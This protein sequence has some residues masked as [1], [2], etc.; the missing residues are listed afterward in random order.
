M[1]TGKIWAGEESN[2]QLGQSSGFNPGVLAKSLPLVMRQ[3]CQQDAGYIYIQTYLSGVCMGAEQPA[4]SRD[5]ARPLRDLTPS[6]HPHSS[7]TGSYGLACRLLPSPI[8]D[9]VTHRAL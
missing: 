7:V 1:R 2:L 5:E 3:L 6:H 8:A 9:K 4:A